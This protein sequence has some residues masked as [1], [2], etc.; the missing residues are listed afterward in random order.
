MSMSGKIYSIIISLLVIAAIIT[1]VSIYGITR[2]NEETDRLGRLANR[3]LNLSKVN[4]ISQGRSIATLRIINATDPGRIRQLTDQFFAPLEQAMTDELAD[5]QTN[6]P[7]NPTED[8]RQRPGRIRDLWNEVVRT[9][10]EVAAL[11]SQ[12]TNVRAMELINSA[13]KFWDDLD[14]NIVAICDSI[15]SD[16][17]AETVRWRAQIRSGR[18]SLSATGLECG[19]ISFGFIVL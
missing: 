11:A 14:R 17:P 6:F 12:N 13:N 10:A 4:E 16:K 2:I 9:T 3:S 8:M 19:F 7:D 15:G 1:G 5:Y 18:A